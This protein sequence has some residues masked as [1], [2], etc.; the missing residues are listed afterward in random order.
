MRLILKLSP[1]TKPVPFDHLHQLTGTIH[2]WL[3]DN[4][5]HDGLSL[6]SFGWL[7]HAVPQKNY[8]M[9]PHGATWRISFHDTEAT[10]VLLD[11]ILRD[12]GVA[13]GMRVLEVKEPA[14]PTFNGHFR[15]LADGPIIARMKRDDGSRK[16]LLWDDVK[17]DAVLTH[18]LRSKLAMAGLAGKDMDVTVEFDRTYSKARSKLAKIKGIA[19]KGS[20]C[21]V[22][23]TG[24]PAA[25]RFA[26]HVGVGELTGSGFGALQ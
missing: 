2:K 16:Y 14:M 26:W 19:H 10:K 21:P 3:G 17:A 4:D 25:V 1:N 5:L 13:Y 11:R 8:L 12:P 18:V 20:E 24:T 15:F 9:F 7:R 23:V 22:L 6:Y